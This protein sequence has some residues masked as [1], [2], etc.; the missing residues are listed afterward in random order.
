M[1][2]QIKKMSIFLSAVIMLTVVMCFSVSAVSATCPY[3]PDGEHFWELE[4]SKWATCEQDGYSTYYCTGCMEKKTEI[5][6]ALG[7][8]CDWSVDAQ[9]SACQIDYICSICQGQKSEYIDEKHIW[10]KCDYNG[11]VGPCSPDYWVS[12]YCMGCGQSKTVTGATEDHDWRIEV[13]GNGCPSTCGEYLHYYCSNYNCYETKIEKNLNPTEHSI[14]YW[15]IE[16]PTCTKEG[17]MQYECIGCS[18][19]SYTEVIPATGHTY[20]NDWSEI[21]SPSCTGQGVKIKVCNDCSYVAHETID[22]LGHTDT[23]ADEIC[24]TCSLALSEKADAVDKTEEEKPAEAPDEAPEEKPGS[25]GSESVD[26]SVTVINRILAFFERIM[27]FFESLFDF[28]R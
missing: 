19:V 10:E 13:D 14:D 12:Y 18:D 6:P 8:T 27:E 5:K 15:E 24:D 26:T 1:K 2:S 11:D 22:A 9:P 16:Y 3:F 23:D 28:V 7:G 21:L 20:L 25:D 17:L 4:D